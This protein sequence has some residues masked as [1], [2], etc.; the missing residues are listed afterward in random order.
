MLRHRFISLGG[1]DTC[2]RLGRNAAT[3]DNSIGRK[4][5]NSYAAKQFLHGRSAGTSRLALDKQ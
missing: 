5:G 2:R 1:H 4:A 3:G